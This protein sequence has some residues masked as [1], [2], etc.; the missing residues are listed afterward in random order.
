MEWRLEAGG[1]GRAIGAVDTSIGSA[2]GEVASCGDGGSN[3]KRV[4]CIEFYHFNS[5]VPRLS[6]DDLYTANTARQAHAVTSPQPPHARY[7]LRNMTL[8]PVAIYERKWHSL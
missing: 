2:R 7:R 4:V 6:R 3:L 5:A 8:L 1:S